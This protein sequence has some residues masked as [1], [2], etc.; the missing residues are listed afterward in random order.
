MD[1]LIAY[2]D[3][4]QNSADPEP[5]TAKRARLAKDTSSGAGWAGLVAHSQRGSLSQQGHNLMRE[6][7]CHC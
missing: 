1:E 5:G 2:F 4:T 7:P 3:K 6:A